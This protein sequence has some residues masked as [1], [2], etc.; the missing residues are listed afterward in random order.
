MFQPYY[1]PFQPN[2]N[3]QALSLIRVNGMDEAK[4]YQIPSNSTVAL[5]D[6][7]E[8]ILYV[9]SSD[10]AGFSTIRTFAFTEVNISAQSPTEGN[11]ISR[12]E[13]EQFKTEV[14]GYAQQLVQ[15]QKHA[16][17]REPKQYTRSGENNGKE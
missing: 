5:F 15:Q 11:Y 9:K 4:A 8:N 13:F 6:A 12:T 3:G 17:H 7:N 2:Y 16:N 1:G 10:N 14:L